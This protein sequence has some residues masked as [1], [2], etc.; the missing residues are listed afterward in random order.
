MADKA[1]AYK[2]NLKNKV[3][4]A[5]VELQEVKYQIKTN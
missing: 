5:N 1:I 4:K 3:A 2:K